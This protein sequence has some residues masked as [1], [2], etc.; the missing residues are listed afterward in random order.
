MKDISA[1]CINLLAEVSL[2][3]CEDTRHTKKL[4][5]GLKITNKLIS[6]NEYNSE[7]KTEFIISKLK[8]GLSVALVSD[9]GLPVISDPGEYLVKRHNDSHRW[10]PDIE[11]RMTPEA[12]AYWKLQ[13]IPQDWD[14]IEQYQGV[15]KS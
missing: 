5:N 8:E 15:D 6:F 2:I 4:L 10:N 1:R 7:K 12:Y 11:I 14:Q 13:G 9:A 3:A